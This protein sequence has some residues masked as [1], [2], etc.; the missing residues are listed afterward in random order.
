MARHAR[1]EDP[2]GPAPAGMV[3]TRPRA[4]ATPHSRP[5]TCGDG[6]L[7][8]HGLSPSPE[9]APHLRGWSYH[10][11]YVN[12]RTGV[13][14][15]PAGMVLGYCI[16]PGIP[17]G[18]PRTCG[19]GP[20]PSVEDEIVRESAPHLRG[21]S[22]G[23]GEGRRIPPVGPAPAGMVHKVLHLGRVIG[24]RPRTCG[25]GPSERSI[26][27]A[28]HRSAPHLRGWSARRK[29]PV[30]M[31]LVGPAPAGMVLVSRVSG[32]GIARR[33]RTCGDGPGL[34]AHVLG[35]RVSAP[36]LRGWSSGHVHRQR[37]HQV[38][39]APAG[40]VLR[41]VSARYRYRCRPRT[42][43]DGPEAP[44]SRSASRMSAPHLRGWSGQHRLA[45]VG[46]R[47]GPAPAGM[48]LPAHLRERHSCRRPRTCG[49]GP[50]QRDRYRSYMR[51]APHLRGWS[52]AARN[53]V[54]ALE[55]RPA[56]AGMVP[57]PTAFR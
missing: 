56:P 43:G 6:P 46:Q 23:L 17:R 47:V 33:P 50:A 30:R 19:D 16:A 14:P 44:G 27:H 39:P 22:D 18:R 3:R 32:S 1:P 20:G 25:D 13:G 37:C 57:D 40:M 49:D 55:V 48:V 9:S 52:V 15:A 21:W 42:C 28:Q 8:R 7:M 38:G 26:P 11:L 54:G 10:V 4:R 41:L 45:E 34:F 29:Q 5:R 35:H 2:V 36:H 53:V 31:D 24:R 51:S 12:T